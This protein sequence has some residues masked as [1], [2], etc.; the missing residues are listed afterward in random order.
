MGNRL[1]SDAPSHLLLTVVEGLSTFFTFFFFLSVYHCF[2]GHHTGGYM[3][4]HK[5]ILRRLGGSMKH[6]GTGSDRI[7]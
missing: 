1:S 2:L 6:G 4:L 7:G 3:H 5:F